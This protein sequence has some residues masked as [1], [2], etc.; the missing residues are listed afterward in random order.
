[1]PDFGCDCRHN[2]FDWYPV[3]P[4]CRL[5]LA[6]AQFSIAASKWWGR[7]DSNLRRHSQRIYSPPPLPLGTLPR[8]RRT[9]LISKDN[10]VRPPAGRVVRVLWVGA[11][12]KSMERR[13]AVCKTAGR[14]GITRHGPK[15]LATKRSF[16]GSRAT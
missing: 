16:Q 4:K 9:V 7:Q 6:E 1:M 11:L 13:P 14:M 3:K 5:R 2:I 8:S 15:I 12:S 10:R